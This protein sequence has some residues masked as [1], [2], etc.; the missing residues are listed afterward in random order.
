MQGVD[1]RKQDEA[2]SKLRKV[3]KQY[4]FNMSYSAQE[5]N[6]KLYPQTEKKDNFIFMNWKTFGD[7]PPIVTFNFRTDKYSHQTMTNEI[8]AMLLLAYRIYEEMVGKENNPFITVNYDWSFSKS[9]IELLEEGFAESL[10]FLPL[11]SDSKIVMYFPSV[12]YK[13]FKKVEVML[14]E[15]A[16]EQRGKVFTPNAEYPF[17]KI[18]HSKNYPVGVALEAETIIDYKIKIQFDLKNWEYV[19]TISSEH[20]KYL[21]VLNDISKLIL[22]REISEFKAEEKFNALLN[23]PKLN[24]ALKHYLDTALEHVY[25]RK[26][27]KV[28][29]LFDYLTDHYSLEEMN[30][31]MN[32]KSSL[33]NRVEYSTEQISDIGG[34]VV[35]FC[36]IRSYILKFWGKYLIVGERVLPNDEV[37]PVY[38]LE[39]DYTLAKRKE[40]EWLVQNLSIN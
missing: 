39:E 15:I 6:I 31:L 22:E 40:T 34:S 25:S 4:G 20:H 12:L 24:K 7:G 37:L 23:G 8:I 10:G 5:P 19:V 30:A 35:D 3:L 27:K 29:R 26:E 9:Q 18:I 38:Y 28:E 36:K 14:Q 32:T 13:Y 17:G 21:A 11:S 33:V 16:E 2:R 1:K